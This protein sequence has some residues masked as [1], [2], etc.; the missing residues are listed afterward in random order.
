MYGNEG[1]E[2]TVMEERNVRYWRRGM[3]DDEGKECT[4]MKERNVR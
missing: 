2:C 1:G 3:Y 4:V